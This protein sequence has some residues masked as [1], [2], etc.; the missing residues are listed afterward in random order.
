M[1]SSLSVGCLQL[2]SCA[3]VLSSVRVCGL[4]PQTIGFRLSIVTSGIHGGPTFG[5]KRGMMMGGKRR[6]EVEAEGRGL[7]VHSRGYQSLAPL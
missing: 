7:L 6:L 3:P 1:E 2:V 5:R 4:C